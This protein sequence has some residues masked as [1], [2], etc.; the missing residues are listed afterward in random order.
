M[1]KRYNSA[2]YIERQG[3]YRCPVSYK[4]FSKIDIATDIK[5]YVTSFENKDIRKNLIFRINTITRLFKALV[6]TVKQVLF[7]VLVPNFK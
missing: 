4:Q 1:L 7:V 6:F 3:W 2:D 5:I